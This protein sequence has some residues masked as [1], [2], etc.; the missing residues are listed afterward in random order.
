MS[1][2]VC[3]RERERKREGDG[4]RECSCMSMCMYVCACEFLFFPA[5]F[6]KCIAVLRKSEAFER[7]Y[8]DQKSHQK[9]A[10]TSTA[11]SHKGH[12][13]GFSSGNIYI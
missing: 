12:S 13:L 5:C 1:V 6:R 8:T 4:K 7:K 3:E 11:A 10:Q 2:Y 9:S